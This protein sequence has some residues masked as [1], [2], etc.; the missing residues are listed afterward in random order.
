MPSQGWHYNNMYYEWYRL[1]LFTMQ[2]TLQ[3]CVLCP[4]VLVWMDSIP[5]PLSNA[6]CLFPVYLNH[7]THRFQSLSL[8]IWLPPR[9]HLCSFPCVIQWVDLHFLSTNVEYFP[10]LQNGCWKNIFLTAFIIP[11]HHSFRCGRKLAGLSDLVSNWRKLAPNGTNLGLF[12]ISFLFILFQI[13]PTCFQSATIEA[14]C[15]TPG[16]RG[17]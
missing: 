9:C 12:K 11:R 16:N 2:S 4:L 1:L 6:S 13:Y 15:D 8:A 3:C 14:K 5:F 17:T 7:S 10:G